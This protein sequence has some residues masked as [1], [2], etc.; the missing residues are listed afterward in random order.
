MT[1]AIIKKPFDTI[2]P[3]EQA[4][5]FPN[6]TKPRYLIINKKMKKKAFTGSCT[7]DMDFA[8]GDD[9]SYNQKTV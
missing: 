1:G 2:I 7:L 3:V 8:A 9:R 5:F 4:Q 6:Q